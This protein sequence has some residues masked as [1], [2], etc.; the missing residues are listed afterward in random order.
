MRIRLLLLMALICALVPHATAQ[1]IS[2]PDPQSGTI[3]GTVTDVQNDVLTGATVSLEGQDGGSTAVTNENGFFSIN[4]VRPGVAYHVVVSATG[5]AKWTSPTVTLQPGQYLE[6][7][8]VTLQ[9]SVA[10]TTVTATL[11]PEEIA[12]EQVRMEEKQRVLGFIPNFYVVYD[13]NAAPLTAKLKFQLAF[14]TSFDP[15]TFLGSAFIGGVDQVGDTPDYQQGL[16]GYGQRFGAN[17]AN[18]LTDIMFGGAILPSLLH[19]DPRY[20]YQGTGSTKSRLR[21]ALTSS[22][23]CKGDNGRWQPNFSSVGGF[24]ISGAIAQT[25]YPESNRGP[26]LVFGTTLVDVA[27]DMANDVIQEF[28]LRRITPAA[29]NGH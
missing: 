25:Y 28:V 10:V 11:S 15:V 18:G 26:G 9:I 19:Q 29:K 4:N 5:F 1:Q 21:H 3:V 2:A 13:H 17:Y 20:F 8:N 7:H 14:H 12:T 23:I 6:I 24:L 22:I 27:A 16:K